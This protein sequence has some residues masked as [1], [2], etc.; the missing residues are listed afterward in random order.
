M[1]EREL[2]LVNWGGSQRLHAL[3]ELCPL[4]E[5]GNPLPDGEANIFQAALRGRV[6][7]GSTRETERISPVIKP[8]T[9]TSQSSEPEH[10]QMNLF[11]KSDF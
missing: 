2:V 7:L 3:Y 5:L 11:G 9:Q 4:D 6:S 1:E 8:V 10:I